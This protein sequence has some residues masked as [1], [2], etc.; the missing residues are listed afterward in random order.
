MT[1]LRELAMAAGLDPEYQSWRGVPAVSSDAALIAMLRALAP[2]LGVAFHD[3][4]D[5][6]AALVELERA[7][8][9]ERVPPVVVAW[10][11][12]LAVP[13]TVPADLDAPWEIEVATEAGRTLRG[14]GSLFEL[15]ASEHASP[16]GV[17]HCQRHV[18]VRLDG[19]LGY[20]T[21][22]WQVG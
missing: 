7:L 22:R 2:D 4:D 16:G 5:A 14:R 15:A 3:A 1:A 10:N 9:G 11:G 17:V 20:H 18:P 8:R 12:E 6:P 13:I 19:E 21:L